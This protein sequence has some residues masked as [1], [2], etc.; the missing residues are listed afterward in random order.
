MHLGFFDD[1]IS[2]NQK[3]SGHRQSPRVVSIEPWKIKPETDI[4]FLESFRYGEGQIE[5]FG[6]LI[7][8]ILQYRK[9]EPM[10]FHDL[11][12]V[13]VLLRRN[14]DDRTSQFPYLAIDFL[15][16]LQLRI[17]I[18]SPYTSIKTD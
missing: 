13:L 5:L 2:I 7:V 10:F 15:Q 11:F 9:K 14:D 8:F 17:A 16:S 3:P 18:R 1:P 12:R 4:Q 6:I